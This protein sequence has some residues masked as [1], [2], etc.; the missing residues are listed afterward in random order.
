VT[1]EEMIEEVR[2]YLECKEKRAASVH[3]A[4]VVRAIYECGFLIMEKENG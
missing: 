4:T 1:Y 3:V 2:G